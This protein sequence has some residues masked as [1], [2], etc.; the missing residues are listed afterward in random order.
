M[1]IRQ[2][3]YAVLLDEHRRFARAAQEAFVTQSAFS[4]QIARL[5]RELGVRLFDRTPAGTVT[6]PAGE[7]FV[8]QARRM[9]TGL[10]SLESEV[11]SIGGGRTGILRV[12]MFGAGAGEFTPLLIDAYRS[13]MPGMEL[14]FHELSMTR[15]F[16]E[17]RAGEVDV[18]IVHPLCDTDDVAFTPLFDEPRFAALSARHALAEAP[19]VSV[20]ELVQHPFV[21]AATGAPGAWRDFWA[22]GNEPRAARSAAEMHSIGEGLVAV[23]YLGVVDTVPS[24]S[25]RYH[26]HPG[27]AFVPLEGAADSSVAVARRSD[28]HR[29]A[30][31]AFCHLA[32]QLAAEHYAVVPGAVRPSA[33]AA[34]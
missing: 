32:D 13:A 26:R 19:S 18:A 31:E 5:E 8:E 17:L 4:Q 10:V 28:D 23:A 24:T 21:L 29:P 15:Q 7:R 27:V 34:G 14:V 22:C 16:D 25:T 3:R 2:L 33:T 1:E 30:I 20:D 11:R 6:T 12:G 9:L